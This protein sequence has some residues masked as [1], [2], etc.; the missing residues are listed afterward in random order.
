MQQ[1]RASYPLTPWNERR[2]W[3]RIGTATLR[4]GPS[5]DEFPDWM[6]IIPN[7]GVV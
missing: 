3:H 6:R 1:R 7:S 5:I 4:R 2:N